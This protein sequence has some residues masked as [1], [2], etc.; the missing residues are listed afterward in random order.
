[1][2]ARCWPRAVIFANVGVS[3][4]GHNG[5]HNKNKQQ[6][7]DQDAKNTNDPF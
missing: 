3:L 7:A 1:M 6:Q 2:A 5:R 4:G